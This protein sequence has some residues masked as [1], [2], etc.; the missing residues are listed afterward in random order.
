MTLPTICSKF[1]IQYKKKEPLRWDWMLMWIPPL[2]S[3]KIMQE[4]LHH[5]CTSPL[6]QQRWQTKNQEISLGLTRADTMLETI[7]SCLTECERCTNYCGGIAGDRK[8]RLYCCVSMVE[9]NTIASGFGHLGPSS[10]KL[11][12][13]LCLKTFQSTY[14]FIW[15]IYLSFFETKLRTSLLFPPS[16]KP[17]HLYWL[18]KYN[19]IFHQTVSAIPIS[20]FA[21]T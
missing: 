7:E 9:I 6:H 21:L 13:S 17:T 8:M 18:C 4:S 3:C 14:V 20:P 15:R 16:T 12:R 19:F 2:F 11:Q 10:K 1:L 5:E